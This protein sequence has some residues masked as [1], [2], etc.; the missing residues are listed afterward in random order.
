M[1]FGP[2]SLAEAEGAL[3]AHG[4]RIGSRV[5]KKGHVLTADDL[6]ALAEDGVET[7]VVALFE[8]GDVSEDAAADRLSAAVAGSGID[9]DTPFTG[10]IAP[11]M[12]TAEK[13][14][15]VVDGYGPPWFIAALTATPVGMRLWIRRPTRRRR[16]A[17][18]RAADSASPSPAYTAPVRLPSSVP[19]IARVVASSG[20]RTSRPTGPKASVCKACGARR[21]LAAST[22]SR[23]GTKRKPGVTRCAVPAIT[24][25]PAVRKAATP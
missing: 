13:P 12:P 5:L 25:A 4:R 18:R 3:L 24:R 17:A 11:G 21:K 2:V 19:R 15:A 22:W 20:E 16:M 8:P 9:R 6:A 23:V 1:R 10:R 14:G 7:V